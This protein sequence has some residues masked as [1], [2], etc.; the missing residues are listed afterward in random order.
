M[1]SP[2]HT[3]L[4]H[5]PRSTADPLE[6]TGS[7]HGSIQS[8]H[9]RY[10]TPRPGDISETLSR[11]YPSP[12]PMLQPHDPQLASAMSVRGLPPIS[13]AQPYQTEYRP[14]VLQGNWNQTIQTIPTR[15]NSASQGPVKAFPCTTCRKGF[16]RRSDLARHGKFLAHLG[17]LRKQ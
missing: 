16:A 12:T 13:A 11:S 2:D 10:S 3:P 15:E 6:R 14:P 17:G 7:P 8:I 9:S 1:P 4:T 5:G